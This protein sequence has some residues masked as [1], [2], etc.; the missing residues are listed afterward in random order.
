[1]FPKLTCSKI[2]LVSPWFV[3]RWNAVKMSSRQ[4]TEC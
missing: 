2:T 1:M 3:S 4:D